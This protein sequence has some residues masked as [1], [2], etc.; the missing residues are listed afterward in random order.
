MSSGRKALKCS[1]AERSHYLQNLALFFQPPARHWNLA[2]DFSKLIRG[3]Y[4]SRNPFAPGYESEAKRRA[5]KLDGDAQLYQP[6]SSLRSGLMTG[7]SG[8]GKTFSVK[9]ILSF[10]PQVIRHTEYKPPEP[11]Q[12]GL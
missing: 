5:S 6:I 11:S 7:L 1:P 4:L 3:S 2:Q 8:S 9:R 12:S 10:T